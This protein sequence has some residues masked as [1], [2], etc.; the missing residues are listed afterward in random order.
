MKLFVS[1]ACLT[2]AATRVGVGKTLLAKAVATECGVAFLSVK[3]PELLNMFVGESERNV[4]ALFEK[5][6]AAAPCVVF[7]DEL[8]SIAGRTGSAADGGGVMDRVVAQLL[9]EL[10]GANS[11]VADDADINDTDALEDDAEQRLLLTGSDDWAASLLRRPRLVF[12]L[13]ATNRPDLLEPSLLR[14]GR[15]DR[16][17]YLGVSSDPTAK[18]R[19]LEAQTRRFNLGPDVSLEA[20]AAA[21]PPSV[22]GADLYALCSS[23]MSSALQRRIQ[24]LSLATDGDSAETRR[25]QG[26]TVTRDV[27]GSVSVSGSDLHGAAS[28]ATPSSGFDTKIFPP[29]SSAA[30]SYRSLPTGA[31]HRL[32][33]TT[34]VPTVRDAASEGAALSVKDPSLTVTPVQRPGRTGPI[35]THRDFILALAS[36]RTSVS[37]A[38]IARYESL[39]AKIQGGIDR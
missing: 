2:Q 9:T 1:V 22:T 3:G 34:L 38:D 20:V 28:G 10:D 23:A 24:A 27:A 15:L 35:V 36:L 31:S 12:F 26:H 6:R 5:A 29:L 39:R 32:P 33:Q 37:P 19:V 7:F 17:V 8:D 4:R 11:D 16:L 14:P 18:L 25:W 30:S 21:C 13:G